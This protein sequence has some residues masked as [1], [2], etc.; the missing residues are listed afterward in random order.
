MVIPTAVAHGDEV[1]T[2]FYESPCEQAALSERV[3]LIGIAH[4]PWF[5]VE[6]KRGARVGRTHQVVGGGVEIIHCFRS[7]VACLILLEGG[8]DGLPQGASA[9]NAFKGYPFRRL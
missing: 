9:F 2:G 7:R 4:A 5:I 6:L 8:I 3:T 1:D